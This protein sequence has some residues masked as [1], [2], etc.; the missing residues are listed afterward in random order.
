M[1]KL[2]AHRFSALCNL[3]TNLASHIL[4]LSKSSPSPLSLPALIAFDTGRRNCSTR[5]NDPGNELAQAVVQHQVCRIPAKSAC[6]LQ[7][8]SSEALNGETKSAKAPR[9]AG[10]E[11]AQNGSELSPLSSDRLSSLTFPK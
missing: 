2:D 10:R 3:E 7:V 4:N 9:F 1:R 5:E 8:V 11:L 6:R